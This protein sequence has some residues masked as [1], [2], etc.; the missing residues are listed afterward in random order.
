[1][2]VSR[3]FVWSLVII[4]LQGL[5]GCGSSSGTAAP[6]A[7]KM[8]TL[9][10]GDSWTYDVSGLI[11]SGSYSGTSVL[12]IT[13]ET[14]TGV[15]VLAGTS[16]VN[17]VSNGSNTSSTSVNYMLQDAI[18]GD[19]HP[20]AMT[21][22]DAGNQVVTVTDRPLPIIWPGT[23]E[24]GK[25]ITSTI[26]YSDNTSEAISYTINGQESVATPAGVITAWKLTISITSNASTSTGTYWFSPE[27]GNYV[28]TAITN[29]AGIFST[30]LRSTTIR[31]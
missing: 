25:T 26:H 7:G 19:V 13:Q 4:S 15:P 2:T 27:I 6:T 29:S 12:N 17:A 21:D 5:L 30:I 23:W 14:L 28:K 10:A 18:S 8:R 3:M 31:P 24:V 22:S 1:M 9:Q 20:Y 11:Q 16:T